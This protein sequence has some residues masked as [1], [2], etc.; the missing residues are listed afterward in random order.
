MSNVKELINSVEVYK[1]IYEIAS[2]SKGKYEDISNALQELRRDIDRIHTKLGELET[3]KIE[4]VNFK[5][6]ISENLELIKKDFGKKLDVVIKQSKE[7]KEFSDKLID[8]MDSIIKSINKPNL[9]P[10]SNTNSET[11]KGE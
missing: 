2:A 10:V 4:V 1:L 3:I 8:K 9:E 5:A 7:S 6:K 11:N